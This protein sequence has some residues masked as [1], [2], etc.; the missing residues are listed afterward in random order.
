MQ[1]WD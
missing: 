1:N